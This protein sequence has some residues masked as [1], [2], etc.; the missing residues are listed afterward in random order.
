M[1]N[2]NKRTS[3]IKSYYK[4]ITYCVSVRRSSKINYKTESPG[5]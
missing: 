3:K 4:Y 1:F 2:L 5:D